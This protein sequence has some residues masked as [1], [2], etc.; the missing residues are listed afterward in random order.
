L[1]GEFRKPDDCFLDALLP[2][3]PSNPESFNSE[4]AQD[5]GNIFSIITKGLG[6]FLGGL[7][8]FFGGVTGME[9]LQA[10]GGINTLIMVFSVF[11]ISVGALI[12]WVSFRKKM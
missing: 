11:S 12:L 3:Q 2:E 9:N 7:L 8:L 5:V 6:I 4:A 10:P 1:Y